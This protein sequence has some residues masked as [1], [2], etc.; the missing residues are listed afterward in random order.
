M[1]HPSRPLAFW[2]RYP[3][4]CQKG[5]S[6]DAVGELW[7]MYFDGETGR[8]T[9]LR[10]ARPLSECHFDSQ[11]LDTRIGEAWLNDSALQG[12]LGDAGEEGLRWQLGYAGA[13]APLYLLPKSMYAGRFPKA[14]ALVPAPGCIFDGALWVRDSAGGEETKIDIVGWPGSQN[15]NWGSQHTSA[16]AW[17]QCAG[18]DDAD[19]AFLECAIARLKYGPVWTPAF[20][21]LTLRVDGEE[22]R[23]DNLL[24]SA[25]D[26]GHYAFGPDCDPFTFEASLRRGDLRVR[27]RCQAARSRFVA[28]TY[29]DP[30]GGERICLNSKLARCDVEIE[31]PGRPT[32]VLRSEHRAAFEILAEDAC[33]LPLRI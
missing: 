17:V 28:L 13:G 3:I 22:L 21:V 12:R 26:D 23:F 30:P 25:L 19:D 33:G 2:L 5:R 27:V 6:L 16:Y 31:R 29:Q 18:F 14:K 4:F 7:G 32:R 10:E 9:A 15:H 11:K 24:R 1:G 8:T 20:T